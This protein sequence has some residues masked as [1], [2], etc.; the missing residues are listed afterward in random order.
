MLRETPEPDCDSPWLDSPWP[1]DG[2]Y[3]KI[4]AS[5]SAICITARVMSDDAGRREGETGVRRDAR[6]LIIDSFHSKEKPL[7]GVCLLCGYRWFIL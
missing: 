5:P 3:L 4:P 2:L 1:R 7:C 6:P